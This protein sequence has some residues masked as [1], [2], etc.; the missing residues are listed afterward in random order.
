MN[1]IE[2]ANKVYDEILKNIENEGDM[3]NFYNYLNSYKE[4]QEHKSKKRDM[5]QYVADDYIE[6][7]IVYYS[8]SSKIYFYNYNN[9]FILSNEDNILHSIHEYIS[10]NKFDNGMN[11]GVMESSTKYAIKSKIIKYIKEKCSIYEH[12]PE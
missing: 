10:E 4:Q 6:N 7:T 12:I 1:Y 3:E 2:D 11:N 5:I 8:K 9:N